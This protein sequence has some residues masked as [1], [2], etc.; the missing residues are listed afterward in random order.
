MFFKIGLRS[1]YYQLRIRESDIPKTAFKTRYG[2]KRMGKV[3]KIINSRHFRGLD[4]FVMVSVS[5]LGHNL[6]S[7][8]P[9]WVIPVGKEPL[10]PYLQMSNMEIGIQEVFCVGCV[11]CVTLIMSVKC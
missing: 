10:T 3:G 2:W 4:F 6:T 1:G 7:S 8:A 9:N 5:I 11:I